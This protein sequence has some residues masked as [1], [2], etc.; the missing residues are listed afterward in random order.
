MLA[1]FPVLFLAR[2]HD[3]IHT[4]SY[5][6]G[7]PAFFGGFFTG[8]KVLITFHE[9]W[10][11]LW[12]RLP[13]FNKISLYLHYLFEQFLLRL[14]FYKF[15][16]VSDFTRKRIIDSGVDPQKVVRIY[17]G[18]SYQKFE[19]LS[20]QVKPQKKQG[21]IF[22][23]FGRLG[24][25]KG[26]DIFLMAI[27]KLSGSKED[28]KVVLIV[29]KRPGKLFRAIMEM[30]QSLQI[31]RYITLLHELEEKELFK[32]VLGSDCV[33][34]P[35]YSEGFC[36]TAAESVALNLPIISSQ[37]GALPEVVSGKF[38][39]F[40]DQDPDELHLAMVHAMQ[41]N[42]NFLEKRKFQMEDTVNNYIHLYQ[43]VIKTLK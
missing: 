21:F 42:W 5:N 37:Q 7:I 27:K 11:S 22:L 1:I 4:T 10:G 24:I 13:F 18:I 19:R 35:S 16:A 32:T 17:N 3:L 15:I 14:P 34:I 39:S 6:A 12:F 23:Y 29:P 31:S 8:R 26:L 41:G 43:S 40:K 30:I 25:S 2:K 36:Y 38:I 20:E 28:F 33:V 9:V